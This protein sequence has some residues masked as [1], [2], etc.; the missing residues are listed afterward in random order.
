MDVLVLGRIVRQLNAAGVPLGTTHDHVRVL[1]VQCGRFLLKA[2]KLQLGLVGI[3]EQAFLLL[4]ENKAGGLYRILEID[5]LV[6]VAWLRDYLIGGLDGHHM[7]VVRH[8][9]INCVVG[10]GLALASRD[11]VLIGPRLLTLLA[12]VGTV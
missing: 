4:W 6:N 3:A 5:L 7:S 1:R 11:L 2:F 12:L 9:R 10:H 8:V